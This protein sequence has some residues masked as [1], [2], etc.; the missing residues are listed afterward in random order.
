MAA[1]DNNNKLIFTSP[2]MKYNGIRKFDR[3]HSGM[4]TFK[5]YT[6]S[7]KAMTQTK[8][9]IGKETFKIVYQNLTNITE[10]IYSEDL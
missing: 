4:K 6:L 3:N 9:K 2:Q 5:M 7:N 1:F 8:Q 10:T